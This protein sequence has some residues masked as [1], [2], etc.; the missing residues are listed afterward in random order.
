MQSQSL[1]Q[2]GSSINMI[3]EEDLTVASLAKL[4]GSELNTIDLNTHEH[5]SSP[6][7][8]LDPKS[9]LMQRLPQ[10]ATAQSKHANVVKHQGMMFHAGV[11]ESLVQQLYPEPMPA[12][13]PLANPPPVAP[14]AAARPA[15]YPSH[16]PVITNSND[17]KELIKILQSIDKTL[18]AID[19]NE[20]A[21]IKIL[22]QLTNTTS[23]KDTSK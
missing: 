8:K 6:A 11:D 1:T 12:A 16:S 2:E 21:T 7:N 4:V 10:R 19:K 9:F 15:T 14:H 23:D 3:N 22:T 5:G 13:G 18:K 17:T 20:K